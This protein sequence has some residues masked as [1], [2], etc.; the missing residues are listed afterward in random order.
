MICKTPLIVFITIATLIL[1]A[2]FFWYKPK[3]KISKNKLFKKGLENNS[4][5]Y[6]TLREKAGEANAFLIDKKFNS[7]I[8]FLIDMSI[9]SGKNRFFVYNTI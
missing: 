1:P 3:F 8:C 4:A 7:E 5:V 2:Y 9:E 6:I